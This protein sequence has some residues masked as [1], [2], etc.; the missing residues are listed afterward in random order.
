MERTESEL[1]RKLR[2][3]EKPINSIIGNFKEHKKI[4]NLNCIN[5]G[6]TLIIW[7]FEKLNRYIL[8]VLPTRLFFHE[9][10]VVLISSIF[11]KVKK[12]K[13]KPLRK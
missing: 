10:I 5:N 9:D 8:A 3:C 12:I 4:A 7:M 1:P 2:I 11:V 6:M 13:E